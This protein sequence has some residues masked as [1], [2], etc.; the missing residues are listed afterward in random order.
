MIC[1]VEQ[2]TGLSAPYNVEE[3][4]PNHVAS[5][6]SPFGF[7]WVRKWRALALATVFT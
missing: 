2:N 7:Q 6:G 1:F 5:R 4:D 3:M